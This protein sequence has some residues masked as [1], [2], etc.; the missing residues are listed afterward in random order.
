M[1]IPDYLLD[2]NL[3]PATGLLNITSITEGFNAS[4]LPTFA[5]LLPAAPSFDEP[6]LLACT[7]LWVPGALEAC[8]GAY[9]AAA[10][11]RATAFQTFLSDYGD[12]PV[13]DLFAPFS[14]A[15]IDLSGLIGLLTGGMGSGR[16]LQQLD[17]LPF[18][19]N[20]TDFA[21]TN[22]TTVSELLGDLPSYDAP[23]LAACVTIWI[24]GNLESC[25][26]ALDALATRAAGFM[27]D[28]MREVGDVPI[29]EM[30][31]G[32]DFSALGAG[33]S[34]EGPGAL[35]SAFLNAL[36]G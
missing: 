11:E 20:D 33:T 12:S 29:T 1:Q 5:D 30:F 34:T 36:E 6:S 17:A 2:L 19:G 25:T 3:D 26:G 31:Q 23:A 15:S 22:A 9:T 14:G 16:K 13:A 24:P 35:F 18:L 4:A 10:T 28:R 27:D 32:F 8:T 21:F 7:Y